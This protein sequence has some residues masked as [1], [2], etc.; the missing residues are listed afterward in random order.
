[1]RF[2]QVVTELSMELFLK[3]SLI[4]SLLLLELSGPAKPLSAPTM[5][6]GSW[7]PNTLAELCGITAPSDLLVP[8]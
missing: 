5:Q 3:R 2:L 4:W 6:D 1:M 8:Q 7:D